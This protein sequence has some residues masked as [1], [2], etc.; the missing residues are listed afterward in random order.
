VAANLPDAIDAAVA[1]VEDEHGGGGGGVLVT[2][3]L[4]T[5]GEA[6]TLLVR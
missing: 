1:L 2:G 4:Y 5:V 3:S 6:R